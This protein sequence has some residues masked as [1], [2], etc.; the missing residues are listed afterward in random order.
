MRRRQLRILRYN[1][2]MF[3]IDDRSRKY[4]PIFKIVHG[5]CTQGKP[6]L[7]FSSSLRTKLLTYKY[8]DLCEKKPACAK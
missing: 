7:D 2:H 1:D 6:S 3:G 5:Y 4:H 8:F